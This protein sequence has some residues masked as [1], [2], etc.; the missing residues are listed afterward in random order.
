MH[1]TKIVYRLYLAQE[2]NPSNRI[3]RNLNSNSIPISIG[4][5]LSSESQVVSDCTSSCWFPHARLR[6]P[7]A[8]GVSVYQLRSSYLDRISDCTSS[9]WFPHARLRLPLAHG[10]S[11]YQLRSSYLD[12]IVEGE[13][14]RK[15][16][17][18]V[19]RTKSD[20]HYM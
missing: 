1:T 15:V 14:R 10:I 3:T 18:P 20:I 11:V 8:H 4:Q 6:L 12:R 7:L 17:H 9:C 5:N 13:L 16:S 19:L 2:E